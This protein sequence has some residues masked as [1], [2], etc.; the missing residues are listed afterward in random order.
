MLFLI[1]IKEKDGRKRM[2]TLEWVTKDRRAESEGPDEAGFA[3]D[4]PFT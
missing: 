1:R 3:Q 2:K 4:V